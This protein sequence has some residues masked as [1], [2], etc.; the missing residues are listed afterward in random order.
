MLLGVH[1]CGKGATTKL[2]PFSWSIEFT[3]LLG[4]CNVVEFCC[5]PAQTHLL[6][7]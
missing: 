5:E 1:P 2:L 6:K 4:Q 7:H 3:L